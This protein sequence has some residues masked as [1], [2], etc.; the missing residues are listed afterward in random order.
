MERLFII[1]VN[2]NSGKTL[3]KL[4]DDLIKVREI[5]SN[6]DIHIV[7]VDNNSDDSYLRSLRPLDPSTSGK[8]DFPSL[9]M[10]VRMIK[11]KK[12]LG[13]AGGC[14]VGIKYALENNADSVL[15]L[16]QDTVIESDF[17]LPLINNSAHLIAPVIKFKRGNNWI[18]DLGGI[19]NWWI[20]RA[21]HL[22]I[23]ERPPLAEMQG[24]ALKIDY[25]S[26][27]CILVK[28]EVFEKIGLLDER[29][30]LYFEDVDFC[31]RAKRAGFKIAVESKSIIIHELIE[32]KQKSIFHKW[33]LLES[34]F[35]FINKYLGRKRILGYLYLLFLIVKMV[36]D[37]FLHHP[38]SPSATPEVS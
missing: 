16:N 9:G 11:N 29:F 35:L 21:R 23:V 17:L 34:N 28:R 4:I 6:L 7:I 13:F 25:I 18:Y 33:H 38:R 15:L 1:I 10:T 19:V 24:V 36:I 37:R 2:F 12:N 3:V 26:G 22:E 31:L 20:G 27:C 5:R 30:F 8:S 32:G 14:N